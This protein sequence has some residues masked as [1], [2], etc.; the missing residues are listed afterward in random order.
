[1]E[2]NMPD[3][4]LGYEQPDTKPKASYYSDYKFD[5]GFSIPKR[6]IVPEN[7]AKTELE[8]EKSLALPFIPLSEEEQTG[9]DDLLYTLRHFHLGDPSTVDKTEMVGDDYVPALLHAYRDASKVRYDYPLFLFPIDNQAEVSVSELTKPIAIVLRELVESYAPGAETARI[10]KDNLSRLEGDLR[11]TLRAHDAP[12]EAVSL[13]SEVGQRLQQALEL[14]EDNRARLQADLDKLLENIPTGSQILGYG[15]YAAIHLLSH[16]IRSRLIPRRARFYDHIAGQIKQLRKL[17]DIDWRK[18]D[19]SIEPK[20]ALDSIGTAGSRFDPV[21]L[22]D[23]MDHSPGSIVMSAQRRERVL[24]VLQV[25]EEY[26]QQEESVLIR[27]VHLDELKE[28]WIENTPLLAVVNDL[29]PCAKAKAIFDQQAEKMAQIFSAVRIAQLEIDGIYDANIHEPWFTNFGWQAFSTEEML[30]L[31]AVI[32]LESVERIAGKASGVGMRSLSRLLSSAR[33]VHVLM[34]V[35]AHHNPYTSMDD[36]PFQ[37]YRFELGYFGISHRQAIISQSSVARHQ[38]LL[39]QFLSTLD[40]TRTSLHIINTGFQHAEHGINAWLVA[41]AALESRA[42]PFFHVNPEAGDY[43]ADRMDFSGNPQPEFDWAHHPF[44][45]QNEKGESVTKELAFTFADYALLIPR[46]RHYFRLVP[47]GYD[48]EAFVLPDEFLSACNKDN[49]KQVPVIWAVNGQG[50]LRKLVVSRQ[51]MF[52][53]HDRLNYWHTL[54]ELAGINN[55]Y[56][57]I[58]VQTARE[59]IRAQAQVERERLQAEHTEQLDKVRQETAGNVM[60]RLADVLLNLDLTTTSPLSIPTTARAT[61]TTSTATTDPESATEEAPVVEEPEV[62]EEV[63][64]YEDP[65]IDSE[66][67]TSCND[68]LNINTVLFVYNESKQAML[69]DLNKGTYAQLVEAAE[70]CQ[71]RCIHPGKPRN[72]DE[73]GL[74]DLIKRAEPYNRM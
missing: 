25:L 45:Y 37:S 74:E 4:T 8:T 28:S 13:L 2:Q 44:Q 46:L 39:Q 20:M 57:E 33:P 27:L 29:E 41:G 55:K 47:P 19:D 62:E 34:R 50:E 48:N 10:L 3:T 18:S 14:D 71:A 21:L 49:C 7:R 30:L 52:A 59:E 53:C 5:L 54:Q 60:Q 43:S 64:Y 12:I 65:W 15:Q 23:I 1:M 61:T 38:H 42:H 56:V 63:A 51:L 40:T 68:C 35:L 17:L 67:C 31:P 9:Q 70:L 26:L 73:P 22:S 24:K 36:E 6:T 58:A 32:A 66:L 11:Q 16:A 69:G 72:P